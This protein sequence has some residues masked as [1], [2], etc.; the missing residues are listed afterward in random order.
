[1]NTN[2]TPS[3]DT[4]T[5]PEQPHRLLSALA[6]IEGSYRQAV[7][8]KAGITKTAQAAHDDWGTKVNDPHDPD[9]HHHLL[10]RRTAA[11][12]AGRTP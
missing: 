1:M 6:L 5:K 2:S 12:L 4:K 10:E 7:D 3:S 9:L 11:L 8:R